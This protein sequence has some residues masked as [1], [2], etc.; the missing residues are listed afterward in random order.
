MIS[1]KSK[2]DIKKI[3][4]SCRILATIMGEVKKAVEP[5]IKTC[6][7]NRLAENLILK[8]KV[9]PAFKGYGGF[10]AA[11]CTSVNEEIVHAAP[12]E[13]KLKEGD[14][15]SLDG[16][17]IYKEFYSDMAVTVPVGKIKPEIA[18]LLKVTK[19]SLKR[20]IK[21]VRPG[22]TFGDLSNTIGRYAEDQGF[23]IVRELCGHGIGKELHEDPQILNYGKRHTGF[24]LKEG[25]CFC[26][27]PMLTM[28]GEGI[29][30]GKDGFTFE[31]DDGSI[32]AHFEHT[33]LVTEAGHEVLTSLK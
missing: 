28:E 29:K 33:I 30:K 27:E 13:R 2:E 12:S 3:K 22:N 25:M 18:R 6:Q 21:K 23:G 10:P 1:I 8:Y 32:S 9:K 20:G 26:L 24:K 4:E 5:G 11:F 31:T 14:I 7:L 16:G 19:K 17:V 15:I